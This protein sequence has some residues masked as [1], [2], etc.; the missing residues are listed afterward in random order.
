MLRRGHAAAGPAV[1]AYRQG[2]TADSRAG[3]SLPFSADAD[4][5]VGAILLERGAKADGLG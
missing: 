4:A 1:A 5:L 3:A 2:D